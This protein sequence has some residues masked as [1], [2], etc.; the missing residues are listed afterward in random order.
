M[1]RVYDFLKSR[2]ICLAKIEGYQPRV[3]PFGTVN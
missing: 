3:P 2:N 1:K